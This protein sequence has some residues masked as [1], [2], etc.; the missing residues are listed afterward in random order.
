MLAAAKQLGILGTEILFHVY[1]DLESDMM[2]LS[3]DGSRPP[4]VVVDGNRSPTR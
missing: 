3:M 4:E 2:S 1:G